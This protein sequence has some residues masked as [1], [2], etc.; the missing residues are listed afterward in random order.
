MDTLILQTYFLIINI[1]NFRGDLSDISAKTATLLSMQRRCTVSDFP[2]RQVTTIFLLCT[3]G[4][5]CSTLCC[6]AAYLKTLMYCRKVLHSTYCKTN[7]TYILVFPFSRQAQYKR[8]LN[9]LYIAVSHNQCLF[10]SR[11]TA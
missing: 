2:R 3:L 10:C 5:H 9:T 1:N 7:G 11:N 8:G 4:C 6:P